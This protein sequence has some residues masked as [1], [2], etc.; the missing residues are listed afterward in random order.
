MSRKPA[1]REFEQGVDE[2]EPDSGARTYKA[3]FENTGTATMIIE[4][5][6][7]ISMVNSEFERL[8][9]YRK[10]EI[11]GRTSFP[12][13]IA[14]PDDVE[15]LLGYHR[16][17]KEQSTS[18]PR[19]YEVDLVTRSGR[20]KNALI[21]AD[22][23][24][25]TTRSVISILDVTE[26]KQLQEAYKQE[27]DY[28]DHILEYSPDGIAIANKRGELI[29]FNRIAAEISGYTSEEIQ[30][31]PAS[32]FYADREEMDRVFE[33]L[34]SQGEVRNHEIDFLR[35]DGTRA[36]S[37]VS[38]SL[39]RSGTGKVMG[40]ITILR[41]LREWKEM[42]E[43]VREEEEKFKGIA[44][45]AL[46]AIVMVDD[47]GCIS[48]WNPAAEKIFGYTEQEVL[49]RDLHQLLAPQRYHE[50]FRKGFHVFRRRGEGYKVG[51]SMELSA[52]HRNGTEFPVEVSLSPLKLRNAWHSVGIVRDI[53]DRKI[54]EAKL[55]K[56]ANTDQLTG[57]YNRHKLLE[58]LDYEI[59][60][61]QRN[62]ASL[63][64]VMLDIDHFKWINDTYGH[65]TG[66]E[67]LRELV[68]IIQDSLRQVDILTRWGGEEFLVLAPDTNKLAAAALA[69]RLRWTVSE[70]EFPQVGKITVSLGIAE[71]GG[72]ETAD[73]LLSRVDE[74]MYLA[75][76]SGR[77]RVK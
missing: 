37:S 59:K 13:F 17:R 58:S 18:A 4:E 5:D 47:A 15:R 12:P 66:D 31:K 45:S 67:V 51:R 10:E 20:I 46:D 7:T 49:G 2:T 9:E 40:S 53:S 1:S 63:S 74:R 65:S 29:R 44:S 25:G 54:M 30:G 8:S 62:K 38:I 32:E 33:A 52:L 77:N 34:R 60:R 26:Y 43:T 50:A 68:R 21:T 71:Y 36:P 39:L 64:L 19:K 28:L 22:L 70:H 23:I 48:Y 3:I 42:L 56:M 6:G 41:D 24:P 11:Q 61:I 55:E 35:K 75:K 72:K 57:A 76:Q 14:H 16:Q 69:E 27:R 73:E